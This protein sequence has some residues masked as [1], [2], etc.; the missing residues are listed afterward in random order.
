MNILN[1][2]EL[3]KAN[4]IKGIVAKEVTKLDAKKELELSRRQIDRL[5]KKYLKEGDD[6]F[7]HKNKGKKSN[8]KISTETVEKIVNL[9]IKEY[10]DYNFTHF[11]EETSDQ[12]GVSFVTVYNVLNEADII[13]PEAQHKAIKLYNEKMKKSI[14]EET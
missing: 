9:Y 5:I 10:Y 4:I 2:N 8:K 14:C 7:I 3:K 13:S 11:Y 12:L 1:E 6:A